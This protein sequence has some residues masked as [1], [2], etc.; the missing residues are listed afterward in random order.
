[1][2]CNAVEKSKYLDLVICLY[3]VRVQFP[4][5]DIYLDMYITS[6]LGQLS[7]AIP[8]WIGIMSTSQKVVTPRRWRVK[9]GIWF[10]CGWQVKLCDPILKHGPYLSAFEVYNHTT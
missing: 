4:V 10:V 2:Q 1:M 9:A 6:H 7:L 5:W 8:S 3:C